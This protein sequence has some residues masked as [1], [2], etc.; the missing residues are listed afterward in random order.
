MKEQEDEIMRRQMKKEKSR[1]EDERNEGTSEQGV[2]GGKL[3]RK[4]KNCPV[5]KHTNIEV[6]SSL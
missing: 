1:L 3:M 4:K 5:L 2:K 6:I